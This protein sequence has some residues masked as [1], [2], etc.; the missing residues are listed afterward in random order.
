MGSKVFVEITAKHDV[1]GN[2]RPLSVKWEDGRVFEVDKVF[3]I[4]VE[5]HP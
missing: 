1:Y 2:I 3:W 5:R 4:Y